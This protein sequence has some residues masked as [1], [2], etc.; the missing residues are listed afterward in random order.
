[1]PI[2]YPFVL[3]KL[4][5]FFFHGFYILKNTFIFSNDNLCLADN[6]VAE[7]PTG[8]GTIA[9]ISGFR[10]VFHSSYDPYGRITLYRLAVE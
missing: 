6:S 3:F 8:L 9:P 1:M 4:F 10:I 7:R 5:L 2:K